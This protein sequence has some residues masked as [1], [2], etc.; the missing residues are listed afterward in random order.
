MTI[1]GICWANC[2]CTAHAQLIKERP[3]ACGER[4]Q[5][6]RS[7]DCRQDE[8]RGVGQ[9]GLRGETD[10]EDEVEEKNLNG[11]RRRV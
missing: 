4:R 1:I 6:S 8:G 9:P 2:F 10:C 7:F 5:R 11:Q 3:R